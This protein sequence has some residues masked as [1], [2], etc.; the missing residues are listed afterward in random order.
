MRTKSEKRQFPVD[1]AKETVATVGNGL[2]EKDP[3]I[4]NKNVMENILS[5]N[6]AVYDIAPGATVEEVKAMFFDDSALIAPPEQLYRLDRAGHR[7]YYRFDEKGNPDFFPSITT[8]IKQT[9]PTSEFLIK[10]IADIGYDR[11]ESYKNERGNYGTFMHGEYAQ[12]LIN[13]TY[14]LDSLVTRLSNYIW[15]NR[16]PHDFIDYADDLRKN[17]LSLAQF[18]ID[19]DLKPLAI[20]LPLVHPYMR[21]AATLDLPCTIKYKGERFPCIIDFKSGKNFY[22]AC[23]VQLH[24]QKECWNFHFDKMPIQRVFNWRPKEWRDKPTYH[25]QEQTHSVNAAKLKYIIAMAQIEDGK[26]DNMLTLC[27]GVIDLDK[28]KITDNYKVFTLAQ[29]VVKKK[30][31]R[32]PDEKTGII[33]ADLTPT[34]EY[35]MEVAEADFKPQPTKR[36]KKA[37]AKQSAPAKAKKAGKGTTMPKAKA[38]PEKAIKTPKTDA[39]KNL[40]NIEPEI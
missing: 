14:D 37:P 22:E 38:S 12:M 4:W 32:T 39:R 40:L 21:F 16:L 26:L 1:P 30:A 27:D 31:E 17:M 3:E 23:E 10:W 19:M 34:P 18:I 2:F 29:L 15:V 36:A 28:G 13:R 11:A 33:E 6:P 8:L 25:F 9:L 24:G 5:Q 7:Y 35:F 20:E